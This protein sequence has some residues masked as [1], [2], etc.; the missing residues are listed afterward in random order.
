MSEQRTSPRTPFKSRIRITHPIQGEFETLTRNLS[1]D[2]VFVLSQG[3]ELE[4]GMVIQGQVLDLP[5][6][7]P[8]VNMKVARVEAD[9]FGL[10][11]MNE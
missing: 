11:F 3:V 1:D 6:E 2:G 10:Q 7:A 4:E 9:G 8:L 5:G